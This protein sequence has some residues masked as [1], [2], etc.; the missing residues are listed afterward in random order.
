[1]K[2]TAGRSLKFTVSYTGML[3]T[4]LFLC[5]SVFMVYSLCKGMVAGEQ[6]KFIDGQLFLH[7]ILF[8]APF[9]FTASGVFSILYFI[10]HPDD[11]KLAFIFFI[12][13]YSLCWLFLLPLSI[14]LDGKL[15][16]TGHTFVQTELSPGYFRTTCNAVVYY[17]SINDG[18]GEGVVIRSGA[19]HYF[20]DIP[21]SRVKEEFSDSIIEDNIQMEVSMSKFIWFYR[22]ALSFAKQEAAEGFLSWICFASVA[23]VLI[24]IGSLRRVSK[25]RLLNVMTIIVLSIVVLLAQDI[26]YSA[27]FLENTRNLFKG[28]FTFIPCTSLALCANIIMTLLFFVTGFIIS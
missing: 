16:A 27:P 25:W 26:L 17:S 14:N 10:R 8:S 6:I 20:N 23:A 22:R 11:S 18:K 19:I 1:M 9:V 24:S 28:I 21:V 12:V 7:G 15:N 2:G 4:G 13:F 3:L 5:A